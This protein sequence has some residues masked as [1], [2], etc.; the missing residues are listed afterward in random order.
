[1][2]TNSGCLLAVLSFTACTMLPST[3]MTLLF[4]SLALVNG[5]A[6]DTG[7]TPRH[8]VDNWGKKN[9]PKPPK[10]HPKPSSTCLANHALQT[11][12]YYTGLEEGTTGIRPGLSESKTY[13]PPPFLALLTVK[14]TD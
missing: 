12:S 4:S 9:H 5:L 7:A 2:A 10:H 1:M 11:A 13:A 8:E 14:M 6:V 3:I